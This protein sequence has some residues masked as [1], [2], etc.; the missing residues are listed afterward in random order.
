MTR[1]CD[2]DEARFHEEAEAGRAGLMENRN[3]NINNMGQL[4]C[5]ASSDQ[6]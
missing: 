5:P 6:Y 1:Y 4:I 3:I 2:D